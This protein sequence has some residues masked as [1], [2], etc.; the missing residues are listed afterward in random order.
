LL[1]VMQVSRS[2]KL[3]P[4][5]LLFYAMADF[6]DVFLR[7]IGLIFTG[8]RGVISQKMQ[9]CIAPALSHMRL[10]LRRYR[11]FP[12]SPQL[13]QFYVTHSLQK[14]LNSK[15]IE[16]IHNFMLGDSCLRSLS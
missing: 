6:S 2:W 4:K 8:L 1:N 3:W 12:D 11:Y 9:L 7:H 10:F 16:K 13:S 14:L 15:K 5:W